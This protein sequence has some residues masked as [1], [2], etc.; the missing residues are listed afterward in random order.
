M[1]NYKPRV[2]DSLSH[3]LLVYVAVTLVVV[4]PQAT[5]SQSSTS[6]LHTALKVGQL[7]SVSIA[8][9]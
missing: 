6:R 9:I 1:L 3:L 7:V 2:R 8:V 5:Q 4:S